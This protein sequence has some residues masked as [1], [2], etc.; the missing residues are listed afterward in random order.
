MR[1]FLGQVAIA[2]L[3]L[4]Y[5]SSASSQSL[6]FHPVAKG[7]DDFGYLLGASKWLWSSPFDPKVVFVC[8]ENPSAP[9]ASQMQQVRDA[10]ASA[11]QAHSPLVFRGWENQCSQNSAGI[12]I[13]ISDV[14]PHT[15]G[16]GRQ[17]DGKPNG[18][19][20]NFTFDNWSPACKSQDMYTMCVKSI[21]VHEFGHAIGF[22]H[23]QNRPD[24]PGECTEQPQGG[25]G[26]EM[27]TPWDIH[28]VMN[29]C[30]P[31]YNNN[32]QLSDYDIVSVQKA[33]GKPGQ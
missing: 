32:G 25:N 3:A 33:Y 18:M 17:I 13:Q 8:W 12:R 15:K 28:S 31:V 14:G 29:Y 16:L 23:E 22:A 27:L 10:V 4:L 5:N 30:N 6:D 2:G 21:A 1:T 26:D 20:L 11:W 24:T 7:I 19:V 9:F